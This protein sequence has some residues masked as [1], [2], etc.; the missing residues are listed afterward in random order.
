MRGFFNG[1]EGHVMLAYMTSGMEVAR[2]LAGVGEEK[3]PLLVDKIARGRTFEDVYQEL[4]R[5]SNKR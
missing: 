3:V 1:H 2:W 4:E 5:K